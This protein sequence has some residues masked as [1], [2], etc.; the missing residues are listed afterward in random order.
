MGSSN[1]VRP[2]RPPGSVRFEAASAI[3]FG[4]A[5]REMRLARGIAQEALAASAGVE[6][7]HMGKIERGEHAPQLGLIFRIAVA[8]E[9]RA[10]DLVGAAEDHLKASAPL[11]NSN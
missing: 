5:V 1:D 10:S 8:L 9:C 6:R 11:R 4:I 2:G 7:S 3:A